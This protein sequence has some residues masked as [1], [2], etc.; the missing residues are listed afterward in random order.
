MNDI[1][2]INVVNEFYRL[3]GDYEK[4]LYDEKINI[5]NNKTLSKEDKFKKYKLFKP[6]CI[7][8][9]QPV[10][11][12]FT[13]SN[14][15]LITKCGATK[16]LYQKNFTPCN[17]DIQIEKGNVEI[18]TNIINE[19][20]K[21]KE[22]DKNDIIK[23]KLDY[24]FNFETE[25]TTIKKFKDFKKNYLENMETYTD[26]LDEF[27]DAVN[28][29]ENKTEIKKTL[30]DI[31]ESKQQIKEYINMYKEEEKNEYIKEAVDE[32]VNVLQK[33]INKYNNL[34][35]KYYTIES[36]PKKN[37]DVKNKEA[38]KLQHIHT[39]HKKVYTTKDI[40][41]NIDASYKIISNKK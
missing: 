2:V 5:I 18:L 23:I 14:K 9:K 4:T 39:L 6:K 36:Q 16:S 29:E 10:G 21:E 20:Y 34:K 33:L 17:L 25:D 12:I 22:E 7:N 32:Y 19:F 35:Y 40:E 11:T 8:C 13:I 1:E 15:K 3:K 28:S 38:D 31:A 41:I 24:F 37:I 30:L 27:N 26:Y